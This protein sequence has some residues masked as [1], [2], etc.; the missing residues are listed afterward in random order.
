MKTTF[1]SLTAL[2][3]FI[4]SP[5]ASQASDKEVKEARCTH[6]CYAKGHQQVA[7]FVSGKGVESQPAPRMQSVTKGQVGQGVGVTY[8]AG[9]R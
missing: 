3:A 9:D 5:I 6:A 2:T 8:F 4:L 1:V 7:L